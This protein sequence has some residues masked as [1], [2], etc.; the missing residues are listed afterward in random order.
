MLRFAALSLLLL[1]ASSQSASH[2][3]RVLDRKRVP[4]A[5]AA[6]AP[7]ATSGSYAAKAPTPLRAPQDAYGPPALLP[8]AGRCF[9]IDQE[10]YQ[11]SLCPFFNV[12]QRDVPSSW[13]SFWG[14][15]GVWE[16]WAAAAPAAAGGG[17]GGG[18]RLR[19]EYTDGTECGTV[20]R[21]TVVTHVC[22]SAGAY[23]L[24]GVAEPSTC[25]Y[26]MTL[27]SPE[28]CGVDPA[29]PLPSRPPAPSAL[30]PSASAAPSAAALVAAPP[31]PPPPAAAAPA[32]APPP[33]GGSGGAAAAGEGAA[34][35]AVLAQALAV[36]RSAE[37]VLAKVDAALERCGCGAGARGEAGAPPPRRGGE[38]GALAAPGAE[39]PAL[40]APGAPALAPPEAPALPAPDSSK[41]MVAAGS[42]AAVLAAPGVGA[43]AV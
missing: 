27:A 17:G 43:E 21:R 3:A 32:L 10:R 20:K 16:G 4:T 40:G 14:L 8:L 11:Y 36:L 28:A 12:T 2:R 34:A 41:V 35:G 24:K 5:A 1:P 38:G 15:L 29:A 42:S 22:S 26:A 6:D 19:G 25:E 37:A 9:T 18:A 39:V 33:P 23:V 31:P 30:P 13:N 7:S